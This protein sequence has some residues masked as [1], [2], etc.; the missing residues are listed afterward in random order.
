MESTSSTTRQIRVRSIAVLFALVAV[1]AGASAPQ[2]NAVAPRVQVMVTGKTGILLP[3]KT[4]DA[5]AFTA[6]VAGRRCL[7]PQGTP[8]AALGAAGV[9]M[10]LKDFGHCSS[11]AVDESGIYADQ[12]AGIT[13]V[14]MAGWM[15]KV[16][17]VAG[18]AGA[19]DGS[20]PFGRGPLASGARVLWFWCETYPC[21]RTL[22]VTAPTSAHLSEYVTAR[23][24]AYDDNG[25]S[26]PAAGVKISLGMYSAITD[27]G[28]Y[29]RVRTPA[30]AGMYY[31]NAI[32]QTK[33]GG[34]FR[35]PAFPAGIAARLNG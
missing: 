18:T 4:V 6:T 35:A 2:A 22:A 32:D 21:Q 11:K 9:S 24:L 25:G 29:G 3:P 27:S 8:L 7:I 1:M 15:F 33:P 16:N 34:H 10:H 31:I 30:G 17:N 13:G 14:G 5:S 26:I 23:V 19:A 20:G 12:I 28:G